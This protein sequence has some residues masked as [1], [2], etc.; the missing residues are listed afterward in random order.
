[1]R[2]LLQTQLRLKENN[3]MT[4]RKM[5]KKTRLVVTLLGLIVAPSIVLSANS[6]IGDGAVTYVYS[7]HASYY[8]QTTMTDDPCGEDGTPGKFH[9]PKSDPNSADKYAMAL[10]ALTANKEVGVL[11][12]FDNP[13]CF[14]SAAYIIEMYIVQ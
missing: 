5:T 11:G 1:M 2:R 10:A 12:D 8:I 13:Y 7:S 6:W 14:N 9:W 3:Q 4:L